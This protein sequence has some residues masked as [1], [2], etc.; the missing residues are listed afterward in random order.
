MKK[1][2]FLFLFLN[3]FVVITSAN[4][5][6]FVLKDPSDTSSSVLQKPYRPGW[7]GWVHAPKR[8][9]SLQVIKL[10][11]REPDFWKVWSRQDPLKVNWLPH[12]TSAN[13]KNRLH[14][15]SVPLVMKGV[16]PLAKKKKEKE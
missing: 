1:H 12:E 14:P 13:S 16:L 10:G 11:L 2:I 5:E 6:A 7:L 15:F 4:E 9:R 8:Q 3:S